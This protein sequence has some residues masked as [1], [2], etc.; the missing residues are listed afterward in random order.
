MKQ[1]KPFNKLKNIVDDQFEDL[2][3]FSKCVC[4]IDL[5]EIE[6]IEPEYVFIEGKKTRLTLICMRSGFSHLVEESINEV[7]NLWETF[8]ISI[9]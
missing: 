8:T 4:L 2:Q 1:V 6:S 9:P 5:G 7:G 3:H